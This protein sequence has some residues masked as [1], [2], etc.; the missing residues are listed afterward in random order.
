M[1]NKK[2]VKYIIYVI[3]VMLLIIPMVESA[4]SLGDLEPTS[5]FIEVDKHWKD[6]ESGDKFVVRTDVK[7]IGEHSACEVTVKLENLP[8]DWIVKPSKH[9]VYELA[10]G[11]ITIN[12]FIIERGEPDETIYAS[13]EALNAPKVISETIAIPIFPLVLILLG[14]VCGIILY[15][16]KTKKK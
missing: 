4:E 8:G 10:P 12:Y 15:K 14:F 3:F 5:L 13:A 6:N 9:E 7:N 11:E 2:N 1:K 16:E